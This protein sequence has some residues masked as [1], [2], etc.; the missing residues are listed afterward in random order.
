L[1]Q[2]THRFVVPQND[3]I[4]SDKNRG[5]EIAKALLPTKQDFFFNYL[6]CVEN[7]FPATQKY[8]IFKRLQQKRAPSSTC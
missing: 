8:P 5:E 2:K 7:S 3:I 6:C 1:F 4:F